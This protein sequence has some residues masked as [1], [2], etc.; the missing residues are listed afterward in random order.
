M[1]WAAIINDELV[2]LFFFFFFGC[3]WT[4]NELS[5][6][7]TIFGR[8]FFQTVVQEVSV[9]NKVMIFMHD[10]APKHAAK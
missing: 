3:T 5:N 4:E 1:V 7:Y 2:G 9:A 8:H 10:N 6:K